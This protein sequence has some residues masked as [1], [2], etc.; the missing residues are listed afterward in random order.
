MVKIFT[1]KQ[2][3]ITQSEK[4]ANAIYA[5]NILMCHV[6]CTSMLLHNLPLKKCVTEDDQRLVGKAK[7]SLLQVHLLGRTTKGC[8]H[9][10][11]RF[12]IQLGGTLYY[13]FPLQ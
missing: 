3:S 6:V 5:S 1:S 10:I 8:T 13:E 12:S 7:R 9:R 11:M 2:A 4:S